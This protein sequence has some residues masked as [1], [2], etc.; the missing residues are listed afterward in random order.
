[1]L[2]V[3]SFEARCCGFLL[4]PCWDLISSLI[5]FTAKKFHLISKQPE[6]G[7]MFIGSA[8]ILVARPEPAF[9]PDPRIQPV[10]TFHKL[11]D[12]LHVGSVSPLLQGCQPDF[13]QFSLIVLLST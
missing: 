3:C 2:G 13:I 9:K 10:L 1:M 7:L 11:V 5:T 12:H 4:Y 8:V 6:F